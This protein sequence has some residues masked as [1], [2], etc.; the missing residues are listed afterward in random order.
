MNMLSGKSTEK[1]LVKLVLDDPHMIYATTD[2]KVIQLS[3]K[4]KPRKGDG[5]CGQKKRRHLT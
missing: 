1:N 5:K 4:H 2:N 3:I